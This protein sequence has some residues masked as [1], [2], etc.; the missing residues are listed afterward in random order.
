MATKQDAPINGPLDWLRKRRR[1][2]VKRFG[3]RAIRSLFG[4]LGRQSLV[5]DAPVLDK[6]LF[7]HLRA[8]EEN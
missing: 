8:L 3:K 2:Y 1:R 4:Y 5:G 6:S 7:P